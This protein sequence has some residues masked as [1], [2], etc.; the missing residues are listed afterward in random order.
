VW[1]QEVNYFQYWQARDFKKY[2]S[3]WD[4]RFVGWPGYLELPVGKREIEKEVA[5]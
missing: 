1:K 5:E 4:D 3:L 2:M